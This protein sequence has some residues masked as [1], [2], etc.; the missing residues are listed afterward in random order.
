M[1]NW[2][3]AKAKREARV[4]KKNQVKERNVTLTQQDVQKKKDHASAQKESKAGKFV[5]PRAPQ[6]KTIV[7][8]SKKVVSESFDGSSGEDASNEIPMYDQPTLLNKPSKSPSQVKVLPSLRRSPRTASIPLSEKPLGSAAPVAKRKLIIDDKD[9]SPAKKVKKIIHASIEEYDFD[10]IFDIIE[11]ASYDANPSELSSLGLPDDV[12]K[13]VAKHFTDLK[14]ITKEL[15]QAVD[16][17]K[18]LEKMR[19]EAKSESER[20]DVNKAILESTKALTT[21]RNNKIDWYSI[22]K[23]DV[24]QPCDRK[25]EDI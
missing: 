6:K 22:M 24:S 14:E 11:G 25:I 9:T 12:T 13:M 19:R 18:L 20:K 15:N 21:I 23:K 1:E 10:L 8:K 4:A 16:D 7:K 17:K 2:A 3:K 5:S